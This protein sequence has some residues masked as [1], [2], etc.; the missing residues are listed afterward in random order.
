MK[1]VKFLFFICLAVLVLGSANCLIFGIGQPQPT[2]IKPN[3]TSF[4]EVT[5][6]NGEDNYGYFHMG[7]SAPEFMKLKE[8]NYLFLPHSRQKIPVILNTTGVS[9]GYYDG[10]FTFCPVNS[11]TDEGINFAYCI[12][13][14]IFIN[15]SENCGELPALITGNSTDSA[16]QEKFLGIVEFKTFKLIFNITALFLI[17]ILLIAFTIKNFY[18]KKHKI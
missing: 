1:A 7:L 15:V 12:S 18:K 2:C 13:I 5:C 4:V 11:A 16:E 9:E 17:M 3:R 8:N 10:N 14:K 6:D